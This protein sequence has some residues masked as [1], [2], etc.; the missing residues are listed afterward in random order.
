MTGD[1]CEKL[2]KILGEL[3][4]WNLE[5][6]ELGELLLEKRDKD[7]QIEYLQTQHLY[8]ELYRR[9]ENLKIFWHTGKR[10]QPF[11]GERCGWPN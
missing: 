8:L 4:T 5:N 1:I 11:G 6:L 3:G 10:S 7:K 2:E 9:R